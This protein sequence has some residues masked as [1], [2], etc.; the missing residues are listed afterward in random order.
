MPDQ[1]DPAASSSSTGL[2]QEI[3]QFSTAEY[4]HLPGTERCKLCNNLIG[5]DYYRV[6][7]LM[8]CADCAA[9]TQNG[10]TPD[11]H[12]AFTRG[13]LLGI[14]AAV[15]GLIVYA[16]FTIITG[17]YIGYLALGIGWL[18]AKAMKKGSSGLG[19]RRY[20]I[21]AVLL[22]YFAIS[23][24]AVPIGISYAIKHTKA[25]KQEQAQRAGAE[26]SG[27]AVVDGD[28]QQP[29]DQ[30]QQTQTAHAH[31]SWGAFALQLLWFGLASPFLELQ[32]P[33]HGLIGLFILFIGLRI[34]WQLTANSPLE[35]D[36]PYRQTA[37]A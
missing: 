9:Q 5:G 25:H 30:P 32:D 7:G 12:A 16:T 24:A 4:G 10:Q 2:T 8:A 1:N 20:Q 21:A 11:S 33:L 18:V 6:N 35:I 13:L 29:Q 17:W 22:T 36:G 34:A 14:G 3:P 31:P 28:A 23:M 26:S 37:S 15:I 19:G 27:G